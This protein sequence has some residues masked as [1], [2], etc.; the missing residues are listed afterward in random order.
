MPAETPDHIKL[1]PDGSIDTGYYMQ[2]GRRKR[3]EQAHRM[4]K[5]LV[6]PDAGKRLTRWWAIFT[7]SDHTHERGV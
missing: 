6:S 4:M 3:S 2:I 7:Q 5:K 1:R